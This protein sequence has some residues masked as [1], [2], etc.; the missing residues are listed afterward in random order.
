MADQKKK[1]EKT[2]EFNEIYQ[3]DVIL[4][5]KKIQNGVIAKLMNTDAETISRWRR[6]KVQPTREN[7]FKL[8]KLLNVN[9]QELHIKTRFTDEI[10]EAEIAQAEYDKNK[11]EAKGN[12]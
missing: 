2:E 10:S 12:R 9:L 1:V 3:I 7:L 5:Q 11:K 6:N 4:T 8:S